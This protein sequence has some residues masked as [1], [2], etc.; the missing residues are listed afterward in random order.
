VATTP[1][2]PFLWGGPTP[3]LAYLLVSPTNN[4]GGAI[5]SD[6]RPRSFGGSAVPQGEVAFLPIYQRLF[7]YVVPGIQEQ[8][9]LLRK[10]LLLDVHV[11]AAV[12]PI[13]R[14]E[15][16]HASSLLALGSPGYNAVSGWI[17]EVLGSLG[18]FTVDYSAIELPGVEGTDRFTDPLDAF[19]QRVRIGDGP[20]VAFYLAGIS[21][22]ATKAAAYFLAS[23]WERLNK[24]FGGRENFCVVLKADRSGDYRACAIQVERGEFQIP[25]PP[26]GTNADE[27]R[28]SAYQ[29]L[30]QHWMHS[31]QIRWTVVY[32]FL[33]ANSILILAW[34][35]AFFSQSRERFKFHL[36]LLLCATGCVL[37]F[38]WTS[39][40]MRSNS[41]VRFYS[42]KGREAE[43]M[44]PE[45]AP[46]PFQTAEGHRDGLPGKA[47][48][49]HTIAPNSR[50]VR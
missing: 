26:S 16:D 20:D 12:A 23:N 6:D 14:A 19:C 21:E 42:Q 31:E 25:A 39:I 11:E 41:F 10:L 38:F 30:N 36:L 7:N 18:R 45:G 29:V 9:G 13:A 32:N 4:H 50:R 34:A 46:R 24:Q 2:T 47:A 49:L 28:T 27:Y 8:P 48:I 15:I 17:E 35:T 43:K 33:V 3:T 1:F 37:S 22:V 5:G 40:A 44:F